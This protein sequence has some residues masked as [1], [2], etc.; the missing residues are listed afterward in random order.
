MADNQPTPYLPEKMTDFELAQVIRNQVADL[1]TMVEYAAK[2]ELVVQ[3]RI[4]QHEDRSPKV[5]VFVLTEV[6]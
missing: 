5:M 1:N 6:A 3:Y 2:R 4:K